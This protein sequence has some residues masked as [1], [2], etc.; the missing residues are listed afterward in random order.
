MDMADALQAA[1]VT[2]VTTSFHE[3]RDIAAERVEIDRVVAGKTVPS[4][5]HE[6]AECF[7]DAAALKWRGPNGWQTL[8]WAGYRALARDATLGLLRLGFGRGEF[9]LIMAR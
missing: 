1:G 6:T 7:P 2:G 9:G 5:L 3:P 4:V 8:T